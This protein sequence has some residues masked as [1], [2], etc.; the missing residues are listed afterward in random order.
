MTTPS[1][2]SW[3]HVTL[4]TLSPDPHNVQP[5]YDAAGKWVCHVCRQPIRLREEVREK[6]LPPHET[7]SN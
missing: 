1:P 6:I 3:E 7:R 2:D 4:Q 5:H